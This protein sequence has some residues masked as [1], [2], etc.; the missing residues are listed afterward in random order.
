[1]PTILQ[2]GVKI[3]LRNS[4]GKY[5]LVQRSSDKYKNARGH[6][7]IVGGRIN[8]GS[9]LIENLR[10]EVHEETELEIVSEPVL[11]DAQDILLP[12]KDLHV[13]RLTYIG[14]TA[15]EPKLDTEENISY[16][17]LSPSEIRNH[18]DLDMYVAKIIEKGLP[19]E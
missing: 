19:G 11:I 3:F 12:E 5:L 1:M 6:W 7:D 15:G 10:R 2:V 9:P 16:A 8:P 18:N 17:W 14:E 4:E 13:V